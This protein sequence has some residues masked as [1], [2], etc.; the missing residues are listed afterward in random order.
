MKRGAPEILMVDDDPGIRRIVTRALESV[1]HRVHAVGDRAGAMQALS[2]HGA[3][4]LAILDV[5]LPDANGL[6][7]CEELRAAYDMPIVMLTVVVD[8]LDVVRALESGADDYVR[9]PF[10]TRELVARI[11]S[12]LRR[13]QKDDKSLQ[14]TIQVGPLQLDSGSYRALIDG[15]RLPLTPTEYRLLAFLVQNAGRVL[16]HDQLLHFVWGAGYEGEHHMLHVT[17]SRLRQKLGRLAESGAIRTMPG[18][19]YEFIPQGAANGD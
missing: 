2:E 13:A 1:N 8:E 18:I 19:G 9:K 17:M 3:Y 16:T 10:G 11:Q 6:D 12:V 4:D 14:Q 15:E 5:N 7:L